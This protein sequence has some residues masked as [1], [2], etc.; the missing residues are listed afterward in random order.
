MVVLTPGLEVD[1][2]LGSS[3]SGPPA[4]A[5]DWQVGPYTSISQTINTSSDGKGARYGALTWCLILSEQTR[6]FQF[7]LMYTGL[8]S[9]PFG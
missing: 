4:M 8:N 7:S 1:E 5:V 3:P 2:M 6:Q 9:E